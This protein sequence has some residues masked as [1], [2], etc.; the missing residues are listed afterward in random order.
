MKIAKEWEDEGRLWSPIQWAHCF[1]PKKP[2][3][4]EEKEKLK[5]KVK[6]ISVSKC[7]DIIIEDMKNRKRFKNGKVVTSVAT[8]RNYHYCRYTLRDFTQEVYGRSFSSYFFRDIDEQFI[9]DYV[10]Y[11][12]ERGSK[13]G[14]KGGVSERLRQFYGVFFYSDKMGVADVDKTVFV[15]VR[16]LC[17]RFK[18]TEPKTIPYE[19]IDKIESMDKSQLTE[20]EQFHIDIFL[21]SFHA[22]GMAN[23]DVCYLNWYSIVDDVIIYERT[24]F[25][26]SAKVPLNDSAK[27]IIRKYQ[28]KCY[29]DYVLPIFSHKHNTEA[30]E[31]GR[32]KRIRER[33]NKTLKKVAKILNLDTEFTWYAARGTFITKMLDLGYHPIAVAEFSGNSPKTI[34]NNYWKQTNIG[35][36]REHMNA[37]LVRKE[38]NKQPE[39]V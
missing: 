26:K 27:N 2:A 5:P 22:G 30:K 21:F 6:V 1:D 14:N 24:K 8:A 33:V 17:K 31:R 18:K 38:N 28:H 19:F 12:Q 32:I 15:P 4:V 23:I 11:L 34:Y 35:D 9:K 20:L 39:A 37:T 10:L 13:K 36:V 29:G 16:H 7:F 25:P 3:N